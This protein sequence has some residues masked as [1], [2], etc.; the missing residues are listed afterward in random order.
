MHYEMGSIIVGL[1]NPGKEYEET[2]HNVGRMVLER[3]RKKYEFSD[4]KFNKM[5]KA[6]ESAGAIGKEKVKLVLP[7]T[8]MN[9]SGTSVKEYVGNP[10]AAEK[11][12]VV[13]DELDIP[14]SHFK[15]SYGRGSGGHRGLES[16]IKSLK[17]KDFARIR[18][19]I[20]PS[21]PSGK[22][23]KPSGEKAVVDFILGKFKASEHETLKKATAK[24]FEAIKM[25]I[26]EGRAKAMGEFN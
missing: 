16:I 8:F 12:I 15:I 4:W 25:I 17:T 21:T 14:L 5:S 9:G 1:G 20:S 6:L 18:V 26:E 3:F 2:R 10:K 11:L 19:G 22:L 13:Y 23:K 7:E 24:I